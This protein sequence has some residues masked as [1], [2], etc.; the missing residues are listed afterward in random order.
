MRAQDRLGTLETFIEVARIGS[1]T[2]VAARLRVTPSAV[3]RR[4]LHLEQELGVRLF[5]RTTRA[6]RLTDEGR[7]FYERAHHAMEELQRAKDGVQRIRQ[8]PMGLLRVEA[9]SILGR[10]L[11]APALP[12]FLAQHPEVQVELVVTDRPSDLASGGIDVAIRL[13]P[14]MDS[15]LIARRLGWT[16]MRVCGAPSYLRRRGTPH[17]LA[18]LGRHER[19]GFVVNGRPLPWR[20]EENGAIREIA[21]GRR[22]V[23]DDAETL[24]DLAV[25]GAGLVWVCD[26]M[27]ARARRSGELVEVL[28]DSGTERS[29]LHAVSLPSGHVLPKVRAFLDATAATLAG[30]GLLATR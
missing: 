18:A 24:V 6:M 3:S 8:K 17:T 22:V 21:P 23:T 13:G 12:E 27:I 10:H 2:R 29:P 28:E 4:I 26:F 19:I 16:R 11:L 30:S 20:L 1:F 25:A 14:L 7:V 5:H 9:P 15:A